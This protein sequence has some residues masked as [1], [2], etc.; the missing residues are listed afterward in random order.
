[1]E[2]FNLFAG[3][4]AILFDYDNTLV[5]SKPIFEKAIEEVSKDIYNFL[6]DNNVPSTSLQYLREKILSIAQKFDSEGTYD[7]DVWWVEALNQ[8]GVKDVDRDQLQEWTTLYWSV[9]QNTPPFDD[10]ID[11][12]DYLKRKGY[13]LGLVTNS[14]GNSGNKRARV[15]KFPLID[16]FD[17]IIIGGEDNVKPKPS[18][19]PF[20]LAC[21]TLGARKENCVMI[22]DDPVKDCLAAK[23]ANIKSILVDRYNSVKYPELY[24]DFV[25]SS[26]KE[27]EEFM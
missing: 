2:D 21:E 20:I 18:I 17:I 16:R 3:S 23:K 10:A 27:L 26:L 5:N 8:L 22:G 11:I 1:M 12:V 6:I 15:A 14:D 19:Q 4:K 9:A 7:R 13:K 25:I 24:A